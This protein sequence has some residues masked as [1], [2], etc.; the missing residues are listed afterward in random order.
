MIAKS[1]LKN[2]FWVVEDDGKKI[3]TIQATN[4]GF[5]YVHNNERERFPSIKGLS[6]KYNITFD[7]AKFKLS[8]DDAHHCY[9]YPTNGKPYNQIWDVKRR[10]PLFTKTDKSRCMFCA[11]YY[12]IKYDG[13]T[14][15][16][17][18]YCPKNITTARNQYIGP[19]KSS[20]ELSQYLSQ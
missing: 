10:V 2:K 11:G 20:L 12:G 18:E 1:V 14:N 17:A 13:T 4:A 16:A 5:V 15:Y 7:T 19:F 8:K 9:G 6:K 3:A